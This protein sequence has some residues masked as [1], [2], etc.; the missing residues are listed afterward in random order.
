[1]LSCT[2]GMVVYVPIIHFLLDNDC[3][4]C[5]PLC[6]SIPAHIRC[7]YYI[8]FKDNRKLEPYLYKLSTS[9]RIYLS[10]IRCRSNYMPVFKV[11]KH[12][13]TYDTKCNV[14]DKNIIGDKFHYL[15]ICPVFHEDRNKLLK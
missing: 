2:I 10:K 13:D 14:C 9:N 6:I 15:F 3:L 7:P 12:M 4:M 11:Y 1:M 8:L 5:I